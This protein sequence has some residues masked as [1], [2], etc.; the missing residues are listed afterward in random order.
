MIGDAALLGAAETAHG[1]D[2][3]AVPHGWRGQLVQQGR[4][5]QP[6]RAFGYGG[7]D[8]LGEPGPAADH[9]FGAQ[10]L[11][12]LFVLLG[13]VSDNAQPGRP[14]QLTA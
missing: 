9:D 13:G 2:A 6:V 10:V 12:Q 4:V 14:A 1:G 11:D 7:A 5:D 8:P 3:A